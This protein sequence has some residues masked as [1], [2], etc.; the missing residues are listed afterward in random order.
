MRHF[1]GGGGGGGGG[2]RGEKKPKFHVKNLKMQSSFL[3]GLKRSSHREVVPNL[4]RVARNFCAC[5]VSLLVIY[6]QLY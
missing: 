5:E 4:S 1:D 3:H 2:G 6:H